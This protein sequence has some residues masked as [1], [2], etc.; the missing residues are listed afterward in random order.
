LTG[1][2]TKEKCLFND[3]NP[4]VMKCFE[5][6]F[7]EE[8]NLDSDNTILAADKRWAASL[9]LHYHPTVTINNQTYRG[10]INYSDIR[11][12]LCQAYLHKPVMCDLGKVLAQ[13]LASDVGREE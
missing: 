1:E 12:A 11:Q 6:S 7:I 5:K 9:N 10:T 4:A 3:T 8:G 2:Y 13:H